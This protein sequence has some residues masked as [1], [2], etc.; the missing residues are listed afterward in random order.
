MYPYKNRPF[1]TFRPESRPFPTFCLGPNWV[2]YLPCR[3]MFDFLKGT[4]R[5]N[6]L[7]AGPAE[8]LQSSMSQPRPHW[9][10]SWRQCSRCW[11]CSWLHTWQWWG[12]CVDHCR[13]EQVRH[14]GR[15]GTASYPPWQ[16]GIRCAICQGLKWKRSLIINLCQTKSFLE[17]KCSFKLKL[18][19]VVKC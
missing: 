17:Q 9:P 5:K 3:H 19:C 1:P 13:S 2:I 10:S 18:Q 4:N 11:G 7:V 14:S 15:S 12:S 6:E 8:L 16:Q